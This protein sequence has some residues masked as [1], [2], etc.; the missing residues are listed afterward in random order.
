MKFYQEIDGIIWEFSS[1]KDWVYSWIQ[2]ILGKIVGLTIGLGIIYL[3][4]LWLEWYGS[5]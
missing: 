2:I 5:K 1:F 4:I 3:I